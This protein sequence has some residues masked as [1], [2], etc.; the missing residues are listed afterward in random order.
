MRSKAPL[1]LMEQ[2]V[3]VLVFALAAALCLRVFVWSDQASRDNEARDRA[4]VLAQS[5]AEIMKQAGDDMARAQD[6]AVERLGGQLSQGL[7]FSFYDGD[8]QLVEQG[9]AV[10]RLETQ[11]EPTDVPGL[12]RAE[13]R[14]CR[15]S[16][17]L[18]LVH[19]PVAWQGEVDEH[20]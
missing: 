6:A 11:G 9:A 7:Y 4:L 12:W 13:V 8:W 15:E 5:A 3:M 1:A 2:A 14:V 17:G 20:G 10:Y 19:L 18:L 16:D